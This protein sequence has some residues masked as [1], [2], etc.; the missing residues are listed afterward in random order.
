MATARVAKMKRLRKGV[1]ESPA[2]ARQVDSARVRQIF[3][4]M[5]VAP[6]KRESE[7]T[8]SEAPADVQSA[9]DL[10]DEE[11]EANR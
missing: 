4:R 5:F 9:P 8:K 10:R 3:E 2:P 7:K 1:Y 11:V 6:K